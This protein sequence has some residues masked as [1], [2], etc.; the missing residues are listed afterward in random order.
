M[1][2]E[3]DS[4]LD[5]PFPTDNNELELEQSDRPSENELESAAAV[6]DID[7]DKLE[8]I[9]YGSFKLSQAKRIKVTGFSKTSEWSDG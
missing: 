8:S 3:R 1:L 4:G 7:D 9:E 2:P 5:E 6:E